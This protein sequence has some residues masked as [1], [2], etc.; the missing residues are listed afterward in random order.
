LQESDTKRE[1]AMALPEASIVPVFLNTAFDER[2]EVKALGA[3]WDRERKSWLAP[4]GALLAPFAKWITAPIAAGT[5]LHESDTKREDAM[6]LPEAS[7]VPVFLNTNFGEREEVKALGA[8]WDRERK[9]W[10][11]PAGAPLAPFAKWISA[12]TAADNCLQKSDGK[13]DD[14]M[15]LPEASTV[16]VF[17]NGAPIAPFA[18]WMVARTSASDASTG[19]TPKDDMTRPQKRTHKTAFATTLL[20]EHLK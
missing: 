14:A 9:S 17:M 4:A 3:C 16:P 18:E 13:R 1:D 10:L 7:A 19:T 2:E 20:T 5:D 15:A 8:R 11:A 6:A 12:P